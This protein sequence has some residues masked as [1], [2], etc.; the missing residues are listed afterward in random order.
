MKYNTPGQDAGTIQ[1]LTAVFPGE[2]GST[3]PPKVPPPPA[4]EENP[5]QLTWRSVKQGQND[6]LHD[7]EPSTILKHT[8]VM[9]TYESA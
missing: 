3:I 8:T 7:N 6:V 1:A 2:P 9:Y 5:R 4:P